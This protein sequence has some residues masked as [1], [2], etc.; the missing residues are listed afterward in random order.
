MSWM[1]QLYKT[2]EEN[3]SCSH[4]ESSITPIAHMNA[5][6]QIEVSLDENGN[7]K[8]AVRLE[9]KDGV[10]LIPVTESSASRSSGIAPHPLSDMLPYIAGDFGDYC[11]DEK[12]K[13]KSAE[14][15]SCY[16]Y[17][18]KKWAESANS[19]PKVKVIYMYLKKKCLMDD[20]IKSGI[21]ALNENGKLDVQKI[22]GQS[23]EKV[24]VRFLVSGNPTWTDG[25]LIEAYT[26]YY[27]LAQTGKRDICYLT[28]EE[29]ILSENHP[30]GIVA[31]A[32]GAKLVSANDVQ[33]YTYRGRFHDSEQAYG[34]SYEASQKIHSALT[35]LIKK[36]GVT[37]G[38]KEKRTFVC[39]NPKGKEV[40]DIWDF[41]LES[42]QSKD[43]GPEYHKKMVK[44]LYGYME[45]FEVDDQIVV[46][47]LEAATTGR[48][49]ITYYNEFSAI[50][51]ISR[52]IEWGDTCRWNYLKLTGEKKP[53]YK[54]ETPSFRRIV[55][56]AFGMQRGN[57]IEVDDK[58]LKE[59]T[60]R[61]LKCMLEKQ[62]LPMDL[63]QALV[64]RASTPLADSSWNRECVLSTACAMIAKCNYDR[65]SDGK[66]VE[67]QMK[68]DSNNQNRSYL[69]GRLLAV[70]EKIERMTYERG[71]TREPNAIRLQ[72]AYVNHPMQTWKILEDAVKPYFQKLYPKKREDYRTLISEITGLFREEDSTVLNCR[73]EEGY[74]LGYYLQ[75]AELNKKKEDSKEELSNE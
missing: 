38:T 23:Y 61:L 9:K 26:D 71:E 66:G 52:I 73:L 55:E 18:L 12:Q 7:F 5:N 15:F 17:Q 2:Y 32:Y 25:T 33:G 11:E 70:L 44:T 48:L 24:I 69:F 3:I 68:L 58:I 75:R 1:S 21:V 50:D 22:S 65:K 13:K 46:M 42:E 45:Q 30:K 72:S 10:T 63:L 36:Q 29:K 8:R 51:F 16:I 6:A 49:S 27:F 28:G 53:Y 19:H 74:L 64:Q 41:G 60:Q 37:I 57:F 31:A 43:S 39:W 62:L 34:L 47:G 59:R 40:P 35:W 56:C 4:N 14:K 20:L 54:E 67:E